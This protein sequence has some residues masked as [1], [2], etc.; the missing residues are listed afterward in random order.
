MVWGQVKREPVRILSEAKQ[1]GV[2]PL[3]Q[4]QPDGSSVFE[5]LKDKHPQAREVHPDVLL[6]E[7][8]DNDIPFHPVIFDSITHLAL[9][10]TSTKW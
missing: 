6:S 1:A 9:L 3:D 4:I 2:I 10:I 8:F 7:I 5:T